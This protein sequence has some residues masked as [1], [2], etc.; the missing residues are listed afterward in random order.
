MLWRDIL[1][2]KHIIV[3]RLDFARINVPI[4]AISMAVGCSV[5]VGQVYILKMD[6][7]SLRNS[8]RDDAEEWDLSLIKLHT[9]SKGCW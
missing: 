6:Q 1:E 4:I 8:E 7:P 2:R 9:Q 3:R 5:L